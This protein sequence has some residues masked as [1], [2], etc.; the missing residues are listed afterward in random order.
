MLMREILIKSGYEV[1]GPAATGDDAIK[2]AE[3]ELPDIAVIDIRLVGG[4]DGIEAARQ[5]GAF[6]KT[7][8]IFMSGYSDEDMMER[9]KKLNPAAYLRK[10][11]DFYELGSIIDSVLENK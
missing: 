4:M 1:C 10:P 2:S 9:A 6:S 7:A 5:I 11:V 8:I 3:K